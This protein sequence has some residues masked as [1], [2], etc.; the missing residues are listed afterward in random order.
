MKQ[1]A[2]PNVQILFLELQGFPNT[3]LERSKKIVLKSHDQ[4]LLSIVL[5]KIFPQNIRNVSH[6]GVDP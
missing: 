6:S 5:Q 1:Q 2:T 3:F 4:V